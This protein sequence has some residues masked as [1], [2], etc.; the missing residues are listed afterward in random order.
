LRTR[1]DADGRFASDPSLRL[2]VTLVMI[3]KDADISRMRFSS[4]KPIEP[5]FIAGEPEFRFARNLVTAP[6]LV[7]RTRKSLLVIVHRRGRHYG[8]TIQPDRR[9]P[10]P[11]LGWQELVIVLL[12]YGA[13]AVALI[14]VLAVRNRNRTPYEASTQTSLSASDVLQLAREAFVSL[15]YQVAHESEQNVTFT[16]KPGVNASKLLLASLLGLIPGIA[17]FFMAR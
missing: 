3:D 7:G 14:V 9:S 1:Q 13:P 2:R 17:Y 16:G 8:R 11:S 6:V 12:L 4:S 10:M 15:G 5:I